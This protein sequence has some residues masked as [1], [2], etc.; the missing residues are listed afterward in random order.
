MSY[1]GIISEKPKFCRLLAVLAAS[2]NGSEHPLAKAIVGF[3]KSSLCLEEVTATI[4]KFNA[5]PGCG[6]SV[7]VSHLDQMVAKGEQSDKIKDFKEK[8]HRPNSDD[9]R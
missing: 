5:V 2:E 7:T 3:V 6:L 8:F 9:S 1:L 4:D